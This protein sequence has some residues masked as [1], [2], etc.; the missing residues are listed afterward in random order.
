MG[1]IYTNILD[2]LTFKKILKANTVTIVKASALWCG[3]CKKIQPHVEKLFENSNDNIQIVYLDIDEGSDLSTYLRIRKLPT[4]I[5][6][7]GSDQ[8][9][10]LE[11]GNIEMV[12]KFFQKVNLRAKL[13]EVDAP[14]DWV[15]NN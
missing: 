13:L 15:V 4:F 9:D 14:H 8:I 12:K 11:G 5:S 6:F 7:V 10:V 2:R 1:H 3:P